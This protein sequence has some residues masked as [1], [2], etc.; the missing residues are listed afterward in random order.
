MEVTIHPRTDRRVA[1]LVSIC[2]ELDALLK[3]EQYQARSG[4]TLRKIGALRS[5][6]SQILK[7][8]KESG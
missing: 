8:I 7:R 4:E 5:R 1:K 2:N 3:H 6:K